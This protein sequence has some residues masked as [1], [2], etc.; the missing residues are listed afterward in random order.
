M[1]KDRASKKQLSPRRRLLLALLTGLLIGVWYTSL[2]FLA[3]RASAYVIRSIVH[4]QFAV[5]R[6][7]AETESWQRKVDEKKRQ[8]A[9]LEAK[10]T[11]WNSTVGQQ[12]LA[13]ERGL[14]HPGE[15]TLVVTPPPPPAPPKAATHAALTEIT[16]TVR[17]TVLSLFSCG[18]IY[19]LLMLR[20]R[21]L[22][23]VYQQTGVLTPR[24]ELLKQR[25]K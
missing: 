10:K 7:A 4:P 3:A 2:I 24:K 25:N 5:H 14:V 17:L 11:W 15:H 16:P 13:R 6:M 12:E 1:R 21:R 19:G 23:R 8:I 20:R 22:I 9:E 18:I